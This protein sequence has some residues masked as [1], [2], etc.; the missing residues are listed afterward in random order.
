M[1]LTHIRSLELRKSRY[2][3]SDDGCVGLYVRVTPKGTKSFTYKYRRFGKLGQDIASTSEIPLKVNG[4]VGRYVEHLKQQ[5]KRTWREDTIMRSQLLQMGRMRRRDQRR[6][7]FR[8][9]EAHQGTLTRQI[10]L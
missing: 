6:S 9:Q 10:T 8:D 1:K 5:E 7:V 3:E 4:L 2:E